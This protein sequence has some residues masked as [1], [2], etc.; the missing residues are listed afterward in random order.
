MI[1]LGHELELPQAIHG[2]IVTY[3][4][5]QTS[6]DEYSEGGMKRIR[7]HKKVR[8]NLSRAFVN[9]QNITI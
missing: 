9:K 1:N 5:E 6:E 8:K 3:E 7:I 2:D 4:K